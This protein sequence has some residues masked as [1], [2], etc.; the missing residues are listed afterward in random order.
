MLSDDLFQQV[1]MTPAEQ[2]GV[3][4]LRI[5]S[6]FATANMADK[7]MGCLHEGGKRIDIELIVGMHRNSG[8]QKAQ[9]LAFQKLTRECA[10]GGLNFSCKY[11][12]QGVPVHAK[13]Y[14]WMAGEQP[15]RAFAGSANYTLTGFGRSQI[16]AMDQ[17]DSESAASFFS[18][19]DRR[20]ANCDREDIEEWIIITKHSFPPG[21]EEESG[22][23][24]GQSM[25][26]TLLSSR[27]DGTY[28]AGGGLNWGQPTEGRNTRDP[29]EAYIPVPAEGGRSGFFPGRGEHF[30]VLTD[31]GY[32]LI[33]VRAQAGG[34]GLETP[35]KNALLGEYLRRRIGV[36]DG[37]FITRADLEA[38]GRTDVTFTKI[39]EE[40][41]LMDFR[42][43]MRAG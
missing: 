15:V 26:L 33:M 41:Y 6:G 31:D 23:H 25:D 21:G 5:V 39:D 8:I 7:H 18:E 2:K 42:P 14:C 13:T 30:T 4:R 9:H 38:Y 28:N 3:D 37:A 35:Q 40:T 36:E 17:V 43:N 34:K 11:V 10:Y 19:I 22:E 1:L 32:T 29:N 12:V 20:A 24:G 27:G 16:E